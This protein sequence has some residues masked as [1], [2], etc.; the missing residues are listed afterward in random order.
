M[1]ND[2]VHHDEPTARSSCSIACVAFV[3]A[4]RRERERE[5]KH[6]DAQNPDYRHLQSEYI[7][8]YMD[9]MWRKKTATRLVTKSAQP[10]VG[11][12]NAR[13]RVDKKIDPSSSSSSSSSSVLHNDGFS[14]PSSVLRFDII[15]TDACTIQCAHTYSPLH[16]RA[17]ASLRHEQKQIPEEKEPKEEE[18]IDPFCRKRT[19]K[20][21]TEISI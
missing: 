18:E 15:P 2:D 8:I 1:K 19:L 3:F 10:L 9:Q 11:Q 16:S 4:Q 21:F 12:R 14:P 7:Y 5:K 20:F 6:T 17:C 13:P